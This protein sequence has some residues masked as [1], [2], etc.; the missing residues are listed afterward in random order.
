MLQRGGLL[1]HRFA[2]ALWGES[3]GNKAARLL[4]SGWWLRVAGTQNGS[5]RLIGL[6][7]RFSAFRL[8]AFFRVQNCDKWTAG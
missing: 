8:D 3:N 4:S 2:I 7:S 5:R 1:L 6:H